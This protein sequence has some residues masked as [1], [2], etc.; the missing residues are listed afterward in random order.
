MRPKPPDTSRKVGRQDFAI[1]AM[2]FSEASEVLGSQELIHVSLFFA[3]V[4]R[5]DCKVCL[6]VPKSPLVIPD[7]RAVVSRKPPWVRVAVPIMVC[8]VVPTVIAVAVFESLA[9]PLVPVAFRCFVTITLQRRGN[10]KVRLW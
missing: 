1:V 5:V 8:D 7:V 10:R 9:L 2:G 6:R 3:L 4:V